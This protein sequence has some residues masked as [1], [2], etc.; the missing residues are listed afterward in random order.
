MFVCLSVYMYLSVLML[1]LKV[2]NRCF[3]A[4]MSVGPDQRKKSDSSKGK[5]RNMFWIP[6]I[7]MYFH[8]FSSSSS[9]SR[10][11]V[12]VVV[13]TAAAGVV[14]VVSAPSEIC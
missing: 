2:V 9:S 13:A 4:F 8:N 6:R 1:T 11:V 3:K 14:V 12:V 5:I 7:L 10:V